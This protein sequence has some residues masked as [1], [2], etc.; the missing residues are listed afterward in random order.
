MSN[1]KEIRSHY[2]QS[3]TRK[4]TLTVIVVSF[5]PMVLV[6]AILLQQFYVAYHEKTRAHLN[7]LVQKH[8]Q[9]IDSFLQEKLSTIEFL[10][11]T[12]GFEKLN[13]NRFLYDVLLNLRR[14]YDNVFV[15]LWL[16]RAN[17]IQ[18][19]YAGPFEL[20]AA[21]YRDAPWFKNAISQPYYISD[22]FSGLR[23]LPHFI[24]AARKKK[25]GEYWL[26]RATINFNAFNSL[27]QNFRLGETGY[28]FILNQEEEFQAKPKQALEACNRCF[29]VFREGVEKSPNHILITR[30]P[31]NTGRGY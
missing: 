1:S 28:A 10:A 2:Y 13:D 12:A 8:K 24:V 31:D 7:E 29:S 15:D 17:G 26:L 30:W 25:N 4:M 27:V 11:S 20:E 21:N 22:V 6:I 19:A 9:N 23:G 3:L 18:T 14:D 5:T 16:I